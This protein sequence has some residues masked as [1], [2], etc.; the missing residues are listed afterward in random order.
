MASIHHRTR[1]DGS[2]AYR[3][4]YR[5]DGRQAQDSFDDPV[6]AEKFKQL[7][8]RVGGRA[9]REFLLKEEVAPVGVP[10]LAEWVARYLDPDSGHLVGVQRDTREEYGRVAERT[11][12]SRLG[13]IPLTT[14]T[15]QG[16]NSWVNWQA[17]VPS[18][19]NPKRTISAQ[20]IKNAHA[21][22][23]SALNAAVEAGIIQANVAHGITLPRG[24]RE[25]I[26]FLSEE[27]F[28]STYRHTPEGYQ[29]M[30]LA[31]ASSGLRFGE[32][33]ALT[34]GDL[35]EVDGGW[36]FDVNKAWK[37]ATSAS[38]YIAQPKSEAGF[39][40][41]SIADGVVERL[42]PR[43]RPTDLI[44][45][46]SR[47]NPITTTTFAQQGL[48]KGVAAAGL[49]R[50]PRVHDLRHSHASWLIARNVPLP[51]IQKRLGHERIDTTISVYGHLLPEALSATRDAATEAIKKALG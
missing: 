33:S 5:I 38:R 11:F 48:H 40:L 13:D 20:T 9:A 10:T 17:G 6:S 8:E 30:T 27:E 43:R 26:V 28:A 46:S 16:I 42:G 1:T 3:V 51:Y 14:L 2:I 32:L 36:C 19:R 18:K 12:L 39:R 50:R 23:S 22:L 25:P 4:S 15:R 45:I 21:L 41:V 7:V 47:G 31:L 29:A 34:W 37:N 44:F 24:R 49:A 35:V